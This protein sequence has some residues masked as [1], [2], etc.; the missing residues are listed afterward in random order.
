MKDPVT[1]IGNLL[2][3]PSGK[4]SV[5]TCHNIIRYDTTANFISNKYYQFFCFS[6]GFQ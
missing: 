2:V 4:I 3:Y 6:G 1:Y 5:L